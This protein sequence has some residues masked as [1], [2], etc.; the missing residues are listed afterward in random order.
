MRTDDKW[1]RNELGI[2]FY[3]RMTIIYHP[4]HCCAVGKYF[5]LIIGSWRLSLSKQ[6]K[7]WE[8]DILTGFLK[9]GYRIRVGY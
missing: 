3:V 6:K 8:V 7:I 1:L 2:E 9:E 5:L 4:F